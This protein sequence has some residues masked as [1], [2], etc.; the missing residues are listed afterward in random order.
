MGMHGDSVAG[1]QGGCS[2]PFVLIDTTMCHVLISDRSVVLR[3]E[4]RSEVRRTTH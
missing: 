2:L 1:R 3:Q 4:Y